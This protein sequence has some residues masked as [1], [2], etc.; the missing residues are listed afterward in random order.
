MYLLHRYS[1]PNGEDFMIFPF[2]KNS[3]R[4]SPLETVKKYVSNKLSIVD[5][6][7]ENASGFKT[8]DFHEMGPESSARPL[9]P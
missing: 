2:T 8:F 9:K 7:S 3:E 6:P 5:R 1:N 4:E